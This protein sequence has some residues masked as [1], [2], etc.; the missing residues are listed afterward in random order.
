MRRHGR[1]WGEGGGTRGGEARQ[2]GG[3]P[4]EGGSNRQVVRRVI[5]GRQAPVQD[6]FA[7]LGAVEGASRRHGLERTWGVPQLIE[8][9]NGCPTDREGE[10]VP[11]VHIV[12]RRQR[13]AMTRNVPRGWWHIPTPLLHTVGHGTEGQICGAGARAQVAIEIPED[14]H[15]VVLHRS[16]LLESSL[17]LLDPRRCLVR[18]AL[19]MA[20][21]HRDA[22][23]RSVRQQRREGA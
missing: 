21:H 11:R 15:G 20:V 3:R 1:R 18:V 6:R 19:Q 23:L 9:P 22:A 8:K 5:C 16:H 12:G 13:V 14:N 10:L 17:Q 2:G 7:M 4:T